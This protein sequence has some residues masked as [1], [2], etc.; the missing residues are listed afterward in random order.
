MT[1]RQN[2]E[3]QHIFYQ[4]SALGVCF[5]ILDD[6]FVLI[7]FITNGGEFFNLVSIRPNT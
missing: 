3:N 2:C 5:E 4:F 6:K 7:K 1:Y